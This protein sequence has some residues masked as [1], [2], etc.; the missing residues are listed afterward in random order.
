M[1]LELKGSLD[2][3]KAL[4][5]G[6]KDASS[7]P[8]IMVAPPHTALTVVKEALKGSPIRLAAQDLHW[9]AKGAFTG[10]VSA[11]QLRDVGCDA[12]I[13]GH[14]ERRQY[15]G[16]TDERVCRK[17]RAALSSGLVPIVCIG[18]T[19]AEREEQRTWRVLETQL[20]GG[21]NGFQAAELSPLVLAYEPVWAIG[22]GKTATP[23]QA[24][25]AHVFVRQVLGRLFDKGFA[26]SVRVLYGGSV[27]AENADSLMAEPDLDGALVGGASLKPE[28]FLRII[29]F[30][31]AAAR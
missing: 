29:Q 4:C 28:S 11:S 30:K 24:Q 22:T 3:A 20:K 23:A 10:E 18:E 21:L 27:T 9:E 2:L 13:I 7:L 14:S 1:N 17:L 6:I 15:F 8:E 26:Q 19:L 12:V 31:A 5:A 25:E 16:E